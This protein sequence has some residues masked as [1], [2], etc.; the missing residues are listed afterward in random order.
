MNSKADGEFAML[1]TESQYAMG[2][3]R[4]CIGHRKALLM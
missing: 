2:L 3:I 4:V 1:Q